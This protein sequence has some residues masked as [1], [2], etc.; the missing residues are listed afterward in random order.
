LANLAAC[1]RKADTMTMP[2]S[3]WDIMHAVTTRRTFLSLRE[4]IQ[5]M[6]EHPEG[7]PISQPVASRWVA[8]RSRWNR[9]AILFLASDAASYITGQHLTI[10]GGF[11]VS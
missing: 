2:E 5:L 1:R 8:C 9:R 6:R 3:E 4:A 7:G 10:D 11:G